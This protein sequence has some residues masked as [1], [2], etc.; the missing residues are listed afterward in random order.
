[1]N[2]RRGGRFASI[3]LRAWTKIASPVTPMPAPPPDFVIIGAMKSA[4]STLHVQ[5][6]KVP[7]IAMS[8]PKEPCFFSDDEVFARG[9]AWY[10]ACFGHAGPGDLRGESST[11]YTKLPTLPRACARL[12]ERRPDAKL[13]Y[14]IRH[15]I[16]RLISHYVHGWTEGWYRGDLESAIAAD[17]TLVDYGRYAMQL[18]P[19]LKAFGPDRILLVAYDGIRTR[20][21]EELERIG[22][23]LGLANT[24]MWSD[25]Q[26]STNISAARVRRSRF[27]A[28]FVDPAWATTLRRAFVPMGIR[29]RIRARHQMTSRPELPEPVRGRLEQAFDEDLAVLSTWLGREIRCANFTES[30]LGEPLCWDSAI[31]AARPVTETAS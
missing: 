6:S 31:A 9:E 24:P 8:T 12:H 25:E 23:F 17:S 20:P 21:Q 28:W 29:A 2:R 11:H 7:G 18:E 15:P 13:V 30:T 26:R 5:L 22:G 16:D 1:M 27:R 14:V 19:W 3:P 4:T 10:D